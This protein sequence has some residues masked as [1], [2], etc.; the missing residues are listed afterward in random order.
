[1]FIN[2]G[3]I[4]DISTVDWPG[5]PSTIIFLR[6]CPHNCINCHN[7]EL[8]K[9]NNYIKIDKFMVDLRKRLN[10]NK[11]YIN[12]VVISGG[13]PVFQLKNTMKI[14]ALAKELGL[15]VAVETSG[16]DSY[17]LV[18]LINDGNID[19]VFISLNDI[20]WFGFRNQFNRSL[21]VLFNSKIEFT[22]R[23]PIWQ[24]EKSISP[25]IDQLITL[26]NY[27]QICM[28]LDSK[29][30]GIEL[31]AGKDINTNSSLDTKTLE[32]MARTMRIYTR[33]KIN[34]KG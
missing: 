6:G 2:V 12:G 4:I 19:H 5:V 22:L 34:V 20:K 9:I 11:E 13:E 28:E 3:S 15:K 31:I 33:N 8:N 18:Q 1:M 24:L 21:H 25:T 7:K 29:F 17:K 23:I 32:N 16:Y 14:A 26:C 27:I 10:T 30:S